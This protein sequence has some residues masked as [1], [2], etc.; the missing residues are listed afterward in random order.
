MKV[1][2]IAVIKNG[3][4]VGFASQMNVSPSPTKQGKLFYSKNLVKKNYLKMQGLN[5]YG[6][7]YTGEIVT[8]ELNEV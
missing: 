3:K 5:S 4:R 2:K 8:F 7:E 6:E 1:Y